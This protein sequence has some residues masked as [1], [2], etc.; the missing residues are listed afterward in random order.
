MEA[1]TRETLLEGGQ[2][3][4]V[5]GRF[6]E[7]KRETRE[8]FLQLFGASIFKGYYKM[9]ALTRETL[10]EGGQDE[11]ERRVFLEQRKSRTRDE[12]RREKETGSRSCSGRAAA[13]AI[14]RWKR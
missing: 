14:T 5:R 4:E 12:R 1:L 9:D 6:Y 7:N 10:L 8:R 2:E 11:A 3:K 13:K